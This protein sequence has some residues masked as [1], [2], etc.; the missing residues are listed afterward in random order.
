MIV[1]VADVTGG[2][3]KSSLTHGAILDIAD[4][5]GGDLGAL[6]NRVWRLIVRSQLLGSHVHVEMNAEYRDFLVRVAL[7]QL[8]YVLMEHLVRFGVRVVFAHEK[9]EV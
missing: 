6:S 3:G 8:L 4:E 5:D 9:M 1:Y 2:D 7:P